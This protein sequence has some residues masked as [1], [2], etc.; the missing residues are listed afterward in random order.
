MRILFVGDVF[1]ASGRAAVQAHLPTAIA[2]WNINLAILNGENAGDR[3][4]GITR[5]IYAEFLAAGADVVTLGN[6]AWDEREALE[7]ADDAPCLV[8]PVNYLAGTPGQGHVLADTKDGRKALVVNALGQLF[9]QSVNNPFPCLDQLLS[10]YPL[11]TQVAATVVDFHCEA[12]SEK[13]SAGWFCDGRASLVVGTHTHTPTADHRILPGGTAYLTD[14]GMTGDYLSV[15]G[16][17]KQGFVDR[18]ATGLP[19]GRFRPATGEATFCGVAVETDDATGL[20]KYIAPV[21]IGGSLTPA[22]PD[23]W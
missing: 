18:F 11:G 9:M 21:R 12:T 14:A 3:G 6:H 20:A 10:E 7:F 22:S 8:R 15:I 5:K 13:Q 4:V 19:G 23:F 17:E 16:V 1:G 2:Q